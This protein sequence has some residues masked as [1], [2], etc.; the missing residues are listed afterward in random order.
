[1]RLLQHVIDQ[2]ERAP[3]AGQQPVQSAKRSAVAQLVRQGS[4]DALQ[5]VDGPPS[6]MAGPRKTLAALNS[7]GPWLFARTCG[8]YGFLV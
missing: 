1:M 2:K 5:F 7:A 4:T 6:K 8:V 3:T